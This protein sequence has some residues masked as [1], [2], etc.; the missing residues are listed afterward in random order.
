MMQVIKYFKYFKVVISNET[1]E[2]QETEGMYLKS[3]VK[4]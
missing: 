3:K 1:T 2:M 4:S